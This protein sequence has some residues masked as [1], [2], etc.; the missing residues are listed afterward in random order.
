VKRRENKGKNL[1]RG[2]QEREQHS[3]CINKILI[4]KK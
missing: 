2:H 3:G 4:N 1:A